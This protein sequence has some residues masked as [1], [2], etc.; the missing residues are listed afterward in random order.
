MDWDHDAML[1]HAVLHDYYFTHPHIT[2]RD[3][4]MVDDSG[5][6]GRYSLQLY[7]YG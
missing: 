5:T 6:C 2:A 3:Q 4:S 1:Q 7:L